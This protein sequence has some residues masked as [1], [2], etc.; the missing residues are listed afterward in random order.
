MSENFFDSRG[1]ERSIRRMIDRLPAGWDEENRAGAR[2][3]LE[4]VLELVKETT[5]DLARKIEPAPPTYAPV[6]LEDLGG[7][8][9]LIVSP[10]WQSRFPGGYGTYARALT[11]HPGD[12]AAEEKEIA[13]ETAWD[14][15]T[16]ALGDP[17]WEGRPQGAT[18]RG[19]DLMRAFAPCLLEAA[20]EGRVA[21]LVFQEQDGGPGRYTPL[22]ADECYSWSEDGGS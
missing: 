2:A 17:W 1:I 14:A 21:V 19:S 9:Y 18:F 20:K 11:G 6:R 4:R 15:I 10:Y 16:E 13:A 12:D 7:A 22:K 3:R 8:A 5:A